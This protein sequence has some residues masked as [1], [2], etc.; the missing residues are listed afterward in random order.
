[1][2]KNGFDHLYLDS[3]RD[4]YSA[5][6]QLIQALPKVAEAASLEEFANAVT[7]HLSQTQGHV[8]RLAKLFEERGES[9][10][11]KKCV[12]MQ[13]L[14]TEAEELINDH[15]MGAVRD[16]ALVGIAQKMEH[17]EIAS[18]GTLS[19]FARV[20]GRQ[21]EADTLQASFRE[22]THA[23]RALTAIAVAS[24]NSQAMESGNQTSE[25]ARDRSDS[26]PSIG[27]G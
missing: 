25:H 16:A 8:D 27:A 18:Y 6:N 13:G 3:L 12:A 7:K 11:G 24:I 1:M 9:P 14:V 22:E 15:D 10:E 4:L 2:K 26:A 20:L 23:D 19:S 5:E 21:A 17:Y